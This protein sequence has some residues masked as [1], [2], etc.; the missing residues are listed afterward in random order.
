VHASIVGCVIPALDWDRVPGR[1]RGNPFVRGKGERPLRVT[2]HSAGLANLPPTEAAALAVLQ[3]LAALPDIEPYTI[4]P[5]ADGSITVGGRADGMVHVDYRRP[6]GESGLTFFWDGDHWPRVAADAL[7]QAQIEPL[8]PEVEEAV[9]HLFAAEAHRA[10]GSDVFVTASP[11]VL[12]HRVR[13]QGDRTNPRSP[14][15]AAR[16]VGLFLRTRD[17]YA[18]AAH[19]S[20]H[21]GG[22]YWALARAFLP[23]LWRYFSACVHAE[24]VRRDDILDLGGAVLERAVRSL[25]AR[26]AAGAAFYSIPERDGAAKLVLREF[27]FLTYVLVGGL[28][29]MARVA[30]HAY[31]ATIKEELTS[32]RNQQFRAQLAQAGAHQLLAVATGQHALDVMT[33][34]GRPRNAIHGAAWRAWHALADD[35]RKNTFVTIPPPVAPTIAEAAARLGGPDRWGLAHRFGDLRL[36]PYTYAVTL[37]VEAFRLVNELAD[38]TDV[39]RL[40]GSQP[41]PALAA[42]P[43]ED[44]V[45]GEARRRRLTILG[46]PGP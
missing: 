5:G 10:A 4:G 14:V 32:F 31:G 38:A 12:S 3:D 18:D 43:P 23:S 21:R 30:R 24:S 34:L 17:V 13:G 6:T 7:G 8:L 9:D 39:V 19:R 46:G 11:A 15:E 20:S 29:A 16:I 41:V 28:D 44:E 26:D 35:S 1:T 37:V 22:F 33:L 42:G 25:E 45:F 2:F 27:D 40:F 36:D